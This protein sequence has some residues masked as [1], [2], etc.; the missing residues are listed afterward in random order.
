MITPENITKRQ[1]RRLLR[2]LEKEARCEVMARLGPF[3]NLEF[4]DYALKQIE[5]KDKIREMLFGTSN[6]VELGKKWKMFKKD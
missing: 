6:L 1:I 3:R 2:L 5:F 4:I